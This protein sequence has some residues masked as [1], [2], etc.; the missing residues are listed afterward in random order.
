MYRMNRETQR[1]EN[2]EAMGMKEK[3]G[4][5]VL[6]STGVQWIQK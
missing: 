2:R 4:G 5:V 6:I 1:I 3:Q